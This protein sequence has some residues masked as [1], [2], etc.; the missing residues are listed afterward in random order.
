MNQKQFALL[1]LIINWFK[2]GHDGLSFQ[3]YR[4]GV[5]KMS[6]TAFQRMRREQAAKE[7]AKK[8]KVEKPK[9]SGKVKG[10]K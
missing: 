9:K 2:R 1:S 8:E 6:A 7:A 10:D 5:I 3:F 4:K